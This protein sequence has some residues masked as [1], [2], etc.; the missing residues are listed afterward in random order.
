VAELLNKVDFQNTIDEFTKLTTA[1]GYIMSTGGMLS[2]L[3]SH[4]TLCNK[5]NVWAAFAIVNDVYVNGQGQDVW[6]RS[7]KIINDTT[8]YR[9][10][11]I[12][13]DLVTESC[14]YFDLF[15]KYFRLVVSEICGIDK[16]SG[17][18]DSIDFCVCS[19]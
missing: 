12:S 1:Q 9:P 5:S 18:I 17:K 8:M 3:H 19:E 10:G 6:C 16:Y 11:Y 2:G 4:D 15:N 7:N 13:S 14:L